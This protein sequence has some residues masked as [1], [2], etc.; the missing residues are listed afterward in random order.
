MK[1]ILILACLLGVSGC[2]TFAAKKD[3]MNR[4]ERPV[5]SHVGH[6]DR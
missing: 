1:I 5:Y 6:F 2:S 4:T 3:E